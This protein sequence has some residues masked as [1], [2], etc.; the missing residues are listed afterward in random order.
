MSEATQPATALPSRTW[1]GETLEQGVAAVHRQQLKM[2]K[3]DS[4][5]ELEQELEE[6]T[7]HQH[8]SA[9]KHHAN[10]NPK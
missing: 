8:I 2:E 6:G 5:D 4:Q 3:K 9:R 10:Q 7:C 1:T